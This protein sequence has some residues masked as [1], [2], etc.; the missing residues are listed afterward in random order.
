[1]NRGSSLIG[2]L[3]AAAI[4]MILIIIFVKVAPDFLGAGGSPRKDKVGH[5]IIGTSKARA[6]DA[7]CMTDLR[8]VRDAIEMAKTTEGQPPTTLSELKLPKEFGYCPI[9]QEP[10]VYDPKTGTVRC[11]HPGHEKY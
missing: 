3:V 11:V 8:Q 9:G 7:V 2:M 4:V 1:M 5:T 10:Y 6:E